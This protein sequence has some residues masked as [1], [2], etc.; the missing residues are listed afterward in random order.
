[1]DYRCKIGAQEDNDWYDIN[2]KVNTAGCCIFGC[3][4]A[5]PL[6]MEFPHILFNQHEAEC[7]F[8][9]Q[10]P[11]PCVGDFTQGNIHII[12]KAI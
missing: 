12:V 11:V 9:L 6:T 1:M 10:Y 4:G 3:Y 5:T 7:R 2:N 8:R